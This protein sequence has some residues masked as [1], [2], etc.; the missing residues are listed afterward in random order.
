MLFNIFDQHI[1]KDAI[2]DCITNS[3]DANK[4]G[5]GE[6]LGTF[7][8]ESVDLEKATPVIRSILLEAYKQIKETLYSPEYIGNDKVFIAMVMD[9]LI[10][11]LDVST[12]VKQ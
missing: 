7:Q 8:T 1:L 3:Y 4:F 12:E 2:I 11:K 6:N 5:T 9:S 10:K